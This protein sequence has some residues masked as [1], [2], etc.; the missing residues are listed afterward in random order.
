MTIEEYERDYYPALEVIANRHLGQANSAYWFDLTTEERRKVETVLEK[1]SAAPTLLKWERHFLTALWCVWEEQA[2]CLPLQTLLDLYLRIEQVRPSSAQTDSM[3]EMG[4]LL[5]SSAFLLF[6]LDRTEEAV[7]GFQ[8]S[9]EVGRSIQD[10]LLVCRS[11]QGQGACAMGRSQLDLAHSLVSEGI[12][13]AIGLNS[14]REQIR[15][16]FLEGNI[17]EYRTN[18]NLALAAYE[19]VL[20]QAENENDLRFQIKAWN[21][22]GNVAQHRQHYSE[23]H[24]LYGKG[25]FLL[26]ELAVNETNYFMD[27]MISSNESSLLF[28]DE[29]PTLGQKKARDAVNL[30]AHAGKKSHQASALINLAALETITDQLNAAYG[31][32]AEAITISHE[33]GS[34][35]AVAFALAEFAR[36]Y[37]KYNCPE[38]RVVLFSAIHALYRR[39]GSNVPQNQAINY[40][41]YKSDLIQTLGQEKFERAWQT[42]EQMT[43]EEAI[44]F[45]LHGC[46]NRQNGT[47]IL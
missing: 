29:K 10:S 38:T 30:F 12:N 28:E 7:S 46:E 41:F 33:L 13:L 25:R 39:I 1:S 47:A 26:N 9:A 44:S 4:R 19:T 23:A 31:D 43:L 5:Y 17:E 18:Y 35:R 36:L 32:L 40:E 14:A 6:W 27:A 45:A 16:R 21:G 8:A 11:L 2:G 20:T 22:L 34:L 24:R 42:G 37:E 15:C 3:I